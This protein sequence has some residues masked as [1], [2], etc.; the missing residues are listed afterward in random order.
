M[1]DIQLIRGFE[2]T[3]GNI[4]CDHRLCSRRI[5]NN[6]TNIGTTD[7]DGN[8]FV[9]CQF[10]LTATKY[11]LMDIFCFIIYI[12]WHIC[13]TCWHILIEQTSSG[14]SRLTSDPTWSSFIDTASSS[15]S[16]SVTDR[17]ASNTPF[18]NSTST[19]TR[20]PYSSS[21]AGKDLDYKKVS[22]ASINTCFYVFRMYNKLDL[23]N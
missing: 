13:H 11:V 7:I 18:S 2:P 9:C 5:D 15:T 23:F 4:C 21:V 3:T 6:T 16:V 19:F 17:S 1:I 22:H 10:C 20:F 12:Y 8:N 14:V